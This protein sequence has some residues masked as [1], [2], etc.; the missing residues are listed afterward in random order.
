MLKKQ[1]TYENWDGQTVTETIHFHL[2]KSDVLGELSLLDR[3]EEFKKVVEGPKR[4]LTTAEKQ[5]LVDLIKTFA[6]LS[7]GKRLD[8]GGFRKTPETWQEFLDSAAWDAFFWGLFTNQDEFA[9]WMSGILPNDLAE[10]ARKQIAQIEGQEQLPFQEAPPIPIVQD[11]PPKPI[12]EMTADELKAR[13]AE[14][15]GN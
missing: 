12:E 13:L 14:L 15:Q 9:A 1:I 5:E 10:E 4:E 11:T 7:Y 2:T 6:R 8:N 3:F